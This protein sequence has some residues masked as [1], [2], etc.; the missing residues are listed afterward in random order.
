MNRHQQRTTLMSAIYQYLLLHKE[1]AEVADDIH[2]EDPVVNEYF[3]DVFEKLNE[4]EEEYR[5]LIQKN[6]IDWEFDRLGYIEQSILLLAV[7]EL[8]GLSYSK[9]IVIDEAVQLAKKYCDDDT[10]KL[11]NGVL[12]RL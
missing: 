3:Y 7:T 2:D 5:E 9:G 11:I 10:Y 8:K 12:D 4:H 1:L 6:L